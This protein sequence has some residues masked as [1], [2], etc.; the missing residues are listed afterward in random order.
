[1]RSTGQP[2]RTCIG[3][4]YRTGK[5]DLLRVVAVADGAEALPVRSLALDRRGRLPGRGAYLH[6]DP[7]CLDLAEHR[8]A[9]PRALRLTGPLDTS[10]L[11]RWI[12]EQGAAGQAPGPAATGREDGETT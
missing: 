7:R 8:R 11:R 3:C 2:M 10:A 1:M 4:R 9:F 6:P 5:S 12:E